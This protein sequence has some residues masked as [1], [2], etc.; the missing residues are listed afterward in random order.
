MSATSTQTMKNTRSTIT[1]PIKSVEAE[2]IY[3]VIWCFLELSLPLANPFSASFVVTLI[4]D[5]LCS[6][7]FS[8]V[9]YCGSES[10]K[11]MDRSRIEVPKKILRA[12][13]KGTS[14][15]SDSLSNSSTYYAVYFKTTS[16]AWKCGRM[17]SSIAGSKSSG[18][19]SR[20]FF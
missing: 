17:T 1:A 10:F 18:F 20:G 13:G 5:R 4:C 15:Q 3:V 6:N 11:R 14:P 2:Q 8:A 7:S 19:L 9:D 12:H 16:Q